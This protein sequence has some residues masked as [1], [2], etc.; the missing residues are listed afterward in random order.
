MPSFELR[1]QCPRRAFFAL[2][3]CV[4]IL[5]D[6]KGAINNEGFGMKSLLKGEK[7]ERENYRSI[8]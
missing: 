7:V 4:Q 8:S 5:K 2:W 3:G 1:N 6:V